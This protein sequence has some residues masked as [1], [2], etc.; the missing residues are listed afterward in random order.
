MNELKEKDRRKSTRIEI[1]VQLRPTELFGKEGQVQ[2][3]SMGGIRIFGI[4][5]IDVGTILK[6]DFSLSGSEWI[7]AEVLVVWAR[8]RPSESILKYDLGCRFIEIPSD[9]QKILFEFLAKFPLD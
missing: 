6:I 3:I 2:N 1:P 9:S 4:K 8:E 7:T 5:N